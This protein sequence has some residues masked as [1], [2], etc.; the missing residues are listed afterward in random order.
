MLFRGYVKTKNKKCI[1]K[2]KGRTDLMTFEEAQAL[3]EYAGIL[4]KDTVLIDIDDSDQAEILM[5]IV[6]EKQLNCKVVCTTRGKHFFFKN[7]GAFAGCKTHAKLACGLTADIK[8]GLKDSY[9]ICKFDGQERF[10]EWD[11]DVIDEA[12]KWLLPVKSSFDF[13]NMKEGEGRDSALFS[14]ILCLQSAGI[15]KDDCVTAIKIINDHVLKDKMSDADI[16]RI[17]RPEAFDTPVFFENGSFLF[18]AFARFMESE[19]HIKRIDSQLHIF[20]DGYY[21]ADLAEIESA[22]IRHIPTLSRAKRKEVLDYLD[23][24]IREDTPVTGCRW[25]AF[26]NGLL[27]IETD[28][29]APFTP[30]VVV[31]NLIPYDYNPD[32][33]DELMD[34]TLDKIS[35]NDTVVRALLEEMAGACMFRSNSLAGGKAFILTGGGS[36]GKSTY[37]NVIKAML[38]KQN[39]SVLDMKK[40]NDRFSTVMMYNKLANIGDDISDNWL[41][42][43]SEFKKLVTG[44]SLDCEQKGQ[45]KFTWGN[46]YVKMIYSCNSIPRIGRGRDSSAVIRRLVIIPFNARFKSTD[47]DF[48]P[49]IGEKLKETV[50]IQYLINLAIAGLKRVLASNAYS[51]NERLE[52]ELKEFEE[53]NNPILGFFNETEKNE[54]ENQ[55]TKDVYRMYNEYCLNTGITAMAQGEFSKQVK[56]HY[57][58]NIVD[59]KINGTKY[60]LFVGV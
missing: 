54:I 10:V 42:D 6:E 41:D 59:K 20:K 23:I 45:P 51:S 39:I 17:T 7:N 34:K 13:L 4:A 1:E 33:Y 3:D 21:Q 57:N 52:E 28:E 47:A 44:E 11:S 43:S 58:L 12:P 56:K 18:D 25:V 49:F 30:D 24:M 37:L 55:P 16:E 8:V 36:N 26:K 9:A 15:A 60:R 35:C 27:N 14:Y 22:M 2:F 5:D 38:G 31:T 19:H 53:T 50:A 46:P 48:V 40:L 32:A 29:F